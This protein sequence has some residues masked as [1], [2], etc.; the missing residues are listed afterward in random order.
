MEDSPLFQSILLGF[1][2]LSFDKIQ[3]ILRVVSPA[4]Y[5]I[6]QTLSNNANRITILAA[7]QK[8]RRVYIR[9]IRTPGLHFV[10]FERQMIERLHALAV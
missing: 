9:L 4:K 3:I 1:M 10:D 7:R 2:Q 8:D 5:L 6:F